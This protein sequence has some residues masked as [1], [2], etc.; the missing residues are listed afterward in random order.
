MRTRQLAILVPYLFFIRI[1]GIICLNHRGGYSRHATVQLTRSGTDVNTLANKYIFCSSSIDMDTPHPSQIASQ[2][3]VGK[4]KSGK[5]NSKSNIKCAISK[6]TD[7][8]RVEP[9]RR[10]Q[11]RKLPLTIDDKLERDISALKFFF[12]IHGH[13]RVPYYYVVPDGSSK[14]GCCNSRVRRK[15]LDTSSMAHS[16]SADSISSS[17]AVSK[18]SVSASVGELEN[19]IYPT[20]IHGLK[21]GRRVAQIRKQEIY[22]EQEHRNKLLA[23]GLSVTKSELSTVD[24]AS[25]EADPIMD[26]CQSATTSS[27]STSTNTVDDGSAVVSS[28]SYYQLSAKEHGSEVKFFE[29][30]AAL[31]AH[32]EVFGDML[33]PRYFIVPREDPWPMSAWDMQLGNRV[34]N[35]R[36]KCAYN[37]PRFHQILI[38]NGFVFSL[39]KL[40]MSFG[41]HSDDN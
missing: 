3:S 10:S 4:I 7:Q 38:D 35:I 31:K 8:S 29:I 39:G 24:T 16:R 25:L 41:S 14:E 19:S 40:K 5:G 9:R 36:S 22:N 17:S 1:N 27:L 37:Q 18:S 34:R 23:I 15:T 11:K 28:D 13:Y 26:G 6:V 33:V 32:N 12:S 21:L 30:L 2:N 20:E